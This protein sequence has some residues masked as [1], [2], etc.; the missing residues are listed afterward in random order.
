MLRHGVVQLG[1]ERLALGVDGLEA[2]FLEDLPQPV[3][4]EPEPGME[5]VAFALFRV[6]ERPVEVV[7]YR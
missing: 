3:A 5:R 7:Q 1:I 2:L 6:R 4:D